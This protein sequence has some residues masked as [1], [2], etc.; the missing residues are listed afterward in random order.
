MSDSSIVRNERDALAAIY[1]E[2]FVEIMLSD[3]GKLYWNI[4]QNSDGWLK[5]RRK[6]TAA[7]QIHVAPFSTDLQGKV[8]IDLIFRL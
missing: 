7:Y 5:E 8:A 2:D 4:W 1:G 3:S 6:F